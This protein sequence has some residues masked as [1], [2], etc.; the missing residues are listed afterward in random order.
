LEGPL[1]PHFIP[2]K[3]KTW[4]PWAILVSDWLKFI[5][6]SPLKLEGTMNCYFVGMITIFRADYITN[7]ATIGS[8]VL[9]DWSV[10][11]NLL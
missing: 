8:S 1:F 10:K 11:K 6:S 9:C 2:I 3:Q 4:T 7:I 5:K